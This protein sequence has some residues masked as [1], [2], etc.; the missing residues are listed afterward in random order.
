MI[1][2]HKTAEM[3]DSDIVLLKKSKFIEIDSVDKKLW[4]LEVDEKSKKSENPQKFIVL[5]EGFG[6]KTV[7]KYQKINNFYF[8]SSLSVLMRLL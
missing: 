6:P 1:Y 3:N 5:L 2:A 7:P 4:S 8:E